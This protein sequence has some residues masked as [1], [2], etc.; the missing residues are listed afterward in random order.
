MTIM[1]GVGLPSEEGGNINIIASHNTWSRKNYHHYS[2]ADE[3]NRPKEINFGFDENFEDS[4][5]I[6][7]ISV[8]L[9]KTKNSTRL[10]SNGKC[11]HSL[12]CQY[13]QGPTCFSQTSSSYT[14]TH[15][16][17]IYVHNISACP[18]YHSSVLF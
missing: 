11:H 17:I 5:Y 7:D 9:R 1:T 18:S 14:Y 4:T 12:I 15:S 10:V 3:T 13:K 6:R 16:H 2:Y 8:Q